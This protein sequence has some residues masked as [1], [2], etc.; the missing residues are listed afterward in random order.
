MFL[1]QPRNGDGGNALPA[2]VCEVVKEHY[3]VFS[4][5]WELV[6]EIQAVGVTVREVKPKMVRDLLRVASTYCSPVS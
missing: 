4:V 3:P 2:T 6:T 1:S 5:P